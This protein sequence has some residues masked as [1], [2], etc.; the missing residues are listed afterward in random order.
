MPDGYQTENFIDE[1]SYLL[2][3]TGHTAKVHAFGRK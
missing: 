2:I 3:A 1:Q